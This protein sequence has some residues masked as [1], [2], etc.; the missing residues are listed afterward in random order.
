VSVGA[1]AAVLAHVPTWPA[2]LQRIDGLVQ[3]VSQQTLSAQKSPAAHCADM[4]Q[5]PPWGMGV[6]VGV[7]VTVAVNV[8]VAVAVSVAVGVVVAV[9]VA[10]AVG[11]SAAGQTG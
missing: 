1:L 6:L 2:R 9:T 7:A 5:A 4:A 11:V 8:T 10:V 3:A